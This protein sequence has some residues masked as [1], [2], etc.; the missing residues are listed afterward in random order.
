M[1]EIESES[2]EWGAL[3]QSAFRL[4]QLGVAG[5]LRFSGSPR[6]FKSL[7]RGLLFESAPATLVVKS[8]IIKSILNT[9]RLLRVIE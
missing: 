1:S 8:N 6:E 2:F 3:E 4:N 7:F 5:A 9:V